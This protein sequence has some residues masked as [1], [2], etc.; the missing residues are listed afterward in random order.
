M[1][2]AATHC[3]LLTLTHSPSLSLTHCVLF[4][5]FFTLVAV[6]VSYARYLQAH[7]QPQSEGIHHGKW[8][9]LGMIES[10]QQ[11]SDGSA[12]YPLTSR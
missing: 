2:L 11:L 7:G 9:E 8:A 5:L 10:G 3:L 4:P 12:I 6:N 1:S